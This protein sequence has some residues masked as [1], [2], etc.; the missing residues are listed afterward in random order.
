M[1]KQTEID[2]KVSINN[3]FVQNGILTIKQSFLEDMILK[4]LKEL[5]PPDQYK[6]VYTKYVDALEENLSENITVVEKFLF[7]VGDPAFLLRQRLEMTS[8]ISSMKSKDDYVGD[9]KNTPR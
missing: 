1:T 9:K 7:E 2:L 6:N 3:L 4:V 5:L 8:A